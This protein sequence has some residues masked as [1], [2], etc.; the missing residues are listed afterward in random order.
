MTRLSAELRVDANQRKMLLENQLHYQVSENS[1]ADATIGWL[2]TEPQTNVKFH[3]M[4]SANDFAINETTG[5]LKT[6]HPLDR[7]QKDRHHLVVEVVDSLSSKQIDTAQI[8]VDVL[9]V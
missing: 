3:L 9:D 4:D 8:L 6:R 7:E 1:K 5:R 2:T